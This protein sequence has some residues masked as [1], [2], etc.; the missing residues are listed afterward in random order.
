M[1]AP[2]ALTLRIALCLPYRNIF[3]AIMIRVLLLCL[4]LPPLSAG[5]A[6]SLRRIAER[7]MLAHCVA[8]DELGNIYTVHNDNTLARYN[9][10][11]DSTGF[12]RSALNGDIGNIDATNPMRLLLY[13][14]VF[15]KVVLLDRQ[16]ALKS[17]VDL[18]K[19]RI[20]PPTAVAAASDGNLWV[21][22]PVNA[23]LMK[24]DERGAEIAAGTDLRQQLS[25]V[26]KAAFLLERDRRIYLCDTAQGILVFDQFATYISTLP[27]KGVT[28]LQAFDLQ[29]VFVQNDTLHS[30]H[31]QTAI[32]KL[33]PLPLKG[34]GIVN[35]SLS[36]RLL[37]VLYLDRLA[38]Y[39]WPPAPA[40]DK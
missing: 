10:A 14:P 29:L 15:N 1:A 17:E 36:R 23:H 19:L 31:M 33:L 30:Y 8:T 3:T 4:F 39:S 9:E 13:Y 38:L 27:F 2:L 18:R 16:L 22:D 5:A 32:E 21:Y 37:A 26:P 35:V 24:L 6:D 11:G 34:D 40:Q 20:F 28:S 25:F 12:Y 7:P